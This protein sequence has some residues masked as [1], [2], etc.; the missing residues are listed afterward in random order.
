MLSGSYNFDCTYS[1]NHY[2]GYMSSCPQ[3]DYIHALLQHF[4][5]IIYTPYQ[6]LGEYEQYTHE[7]QETLKVMDLMDKRHEFVV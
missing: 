1:Q 7:F 5:A 2:T 6:Y 4:V 3:S